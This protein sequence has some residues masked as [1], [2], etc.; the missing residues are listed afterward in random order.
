[1]VL[2]VLVFRQFLDQ[3][4]QVGTVLGTRGADTERG[5]FRRRFPLRPPRLTS[6]RCVNRRRSCF[7]IRVPGAAATCG[8]SGCEHV[9]AAFGCWRSRLPTAR[10]R[11]KEMTMTH[12]VKPAILILNLPLSQMGQSDLGLVQMHQ[13]RK[14]RRGRELEVSLQLFLTEVEVLHQNHMQV[15]KRS[16]RNYHLPFVLSKKTKQV[17]LNTFSK[18]HDSFSSRVITMKMYHLLRQREYGQHF[19]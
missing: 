10:I 7:F 8:Q 9:P 11:R 4:Q 13:T 5:H 12:G 17:N 3:S 2:H 19:Q 14:R 6:P 16:M 1:M 15:Q 18:M